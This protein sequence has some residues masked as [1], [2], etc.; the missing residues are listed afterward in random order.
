LGVE[1]QRRPLL[2]HLQTVC[3][4]AAIRAPDRAAFVFQ[5]MCCDFSN[6]V[7]RDSQVLTVGPTA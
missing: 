7:L 3:I 6:H 5:T 1:D 2:L 4:S